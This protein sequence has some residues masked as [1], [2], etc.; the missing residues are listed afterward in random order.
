MRI[1]SLSSLENALRGQRLD[2]RWKEFLDAWGEAD[3]ELNRRSLE[4]VSGLRD[5]FLSLVHDVTDPTD[6]D[7]SI[8]LFYMRLKTDWVL[9]NTQYNYQIQD[10]N[11]DAS[12]VC[13]AGM[14]SALIGA[15]EACVRPD[16]L[17]RIGALI[18]Q[19]TIASLNNE[20]ASDQTASDQTASDQAATLG[21]GKESDIA[22]DEFAAPEDVPAPTST[23]LRELEGRLD[24]QG[25]ALARLSADWAAMEKLT[26]ITG[27][28]N[29]LARLDT[30]LR[31]NAR[32]HRDIDALPQLGRDFER[33]FGGVTAHQ[34]AGQIKRLEERIE[35]LQRESHLWHTSWDQLTIEAGESEPSRLARRYREM[36]ETVTEITT[37]LT[38][39][40]EN[41]SRLER[42]IGCW[43]AA[44][45]LKL[46]QGDE[47]ESESVTLDL[48]DMLAD[49][50]NSLKG[51][52]A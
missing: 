14:L 28:E 31:E 43:R 23:R 6:R 39:Y 20:T 35:E 32:L 40:R 22:P 13:R 47:A 33:E 44:D 21:D 7:S 45:I 4:Y 3:P 12:L 25:R 50:E 1:V 41:R 27:S 29:I 2:A 26:Q 15:I 5:S 38:W 24:A 30:V 8:A 18:A 11:L 19:P 49:I 37:E 17:A 36:Q 10:G 52:A 34:V 9:I 46:L 42:E 48:T 16:D 51:M